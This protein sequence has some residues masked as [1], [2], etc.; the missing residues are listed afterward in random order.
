MRILKLRKLS[1]LPEVTWLPGGES[2][3]LEL[4]EAF[5]YCWPFFFFPHY[6]VHWTFSLCDALGSMNEMAQTL[7][8][9]TLSNCPLGWRD[10]YMD[11]PI[12]HL[13]HH[14]CQH[15]NQLRRSIKS[16]YVVRK[17]WSPEGC[18]FPKAINITLWYQN[19]S[20]K[21]MSWPSSDATDS[22]YDDDD[23]NSKETQRLRKLTCIKS[24]S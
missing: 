4:E 23:S 9:Q 21:L 12:I 18:G 2:G 20:K 13:E 1:N 10:Q 16:F 11:T 22:N 5:E 15:A 24:H 14:Q 17:W 19:Q 6:H 3:L 7:L 8:P